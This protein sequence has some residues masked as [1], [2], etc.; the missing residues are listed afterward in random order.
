MTRQSAHFS[1]LALALLTWGCQGCGEGSGVPE[2]RVEQIEIMA[3]D[4][5]YVEDPWGEEGLPDLYADFSVADEPYYT[6]PV[7][8]EASLPQRIDVDGLIFQGAELDQTVVIRI[9]DEDDDSLDDIVGEV[10]FV[11]S[12][13]MFSEPIRH[14]LYGGYLQVDLLLSW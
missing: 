1:L 9:F 4:A 11:P 14:P 7:A 5:N 3:I 10:S 2:V 13:L 8:F 6:S 12:E